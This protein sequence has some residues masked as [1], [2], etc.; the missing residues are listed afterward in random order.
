MQGVNTSQ[1][2]P[3]LYTPMTLTGKAQLVFGRPWAAKLAERQQQD[4]MASTN[5]AM[6]QDSNQPQ[7]LRQQQRQ[8]AV[9]DGKHAEQGQW[10]QEDADFPTTDAN[11]AR[12]GE[13]VGSGSIRN[14]ASTSFS[15]GSRSSHPRKPF[16][17]I[18]TFKWEQRKG[19]DVLLQAYLSEFTSEDDVELYILTKPFSD[20]GSGFKE[21]MR[22]WADKLYGSK[23]AVS[24]ATQ[25]TTP[26]RKVPAA[27]RLR[28][29][30]PVSQLTAVPASAAAKAGQSRQLLE[31]Q[32]LV[33]PQLQQQQQQG[34]SSRLAQCSGALGTT[35]CSSALL[36]GIAA[37]IAPDHDL[38]SYAGY[39]IEQQ[40]VTRSLLSSGL[41][42]GA[43]NEGE[44]GEGDL[45]QQTKANAL[46]AIAQIR[47]YVE[48]HLTETAATASSS[49]QQQR[50]LM[51][52]SQD[53]TSVEDVLASA[54]ARKAAAAAGSAAD[55]AADPSGK[56][57]QQQQKPAAKPSEKDA[58]AATAEEAAAKYPTLYVVDSH[59]SGKRDWHNH[60][61]FNV[62]CFPIIRQLSR[63]YCLVRKGLVSNPIVNPHPYM[64]LA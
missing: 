38:D 50:R 14:A 30:A 13:P 43:G 54:M 55:A 48:Q 23:S 6:M 64:S 35:N 33:E 62:M 15:S 12:S 2:D 42:I 56:P 27:G 7:P 59:I 37:S 58:A 51:A 29:A 1:F 63:P 9:Y 40:Q 45:E 25:P 17:F 26:P 61:V 24:S 34:L 16:V 46:D 47:Q 22:S 11:S 41:L 4:T 18:S 39:S 57:K 49:T 8:Q 36:E 19:W 3:A 21:K 28:V 10:R 5:R 44:Q 20:S 53:A 52:D 60:A 32:Q 31:Q